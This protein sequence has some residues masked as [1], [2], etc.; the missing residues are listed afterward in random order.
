MSE[1][2]DGEATQVT[3]NQ[4]ALVQ[5]VLARYP[6][7]FTVFRE[8]VQNADDAGAENVEIEFQTKD[9]ATKP[10][11][12]KMTNGIEHDLTNVKAFKWVV[13]NDG[14]AFEDGGW[15]RLTN[16][17]DGNPDDQKIGAF[18]VGFFSV[19]SITECPV[20][21]SGNRCK[22]M[23]YKGD[24]LMF[25]F[26]SYPETKW[27]TIEMEVK[28]E[29][30]PMPKPFDLSTFFCTAVT[31]LTKVKRV[32]ILFNGQLL[33]EITKFRGE[34]QKIEE[35]PKE[36]KKKSKS[37][38]MT[39]K[40]V[41]MIPAQQV[42]VTLSKLGRSAGSKKSGVGKTAPE[43]EDA[44]PTKRAG[45]FGRK[46]VEPNRAGTI[47]RTSSTHANSS[48]VN[49]TIYSAH[50]S[51]TP[52]EEMISGLLEA[53]KKRP[54]S[55]FLYEAVHFTRE[56]YQRAMAD[57][58]EEDSIGSV[59][60]GVQALCSEKEEGHASRLFIGQSTAQ[61][62]GIAVHLSSRFTP[63]VER[64]SIDLALKDHLREEALYIMKCFTSRQ[65]TPDSKVGELLQNAFFN[66]STSPSFPILSN[67]GIRDS[68][69]VRQPHTDFKPFMK[70]RPVLDNAL[71][72]INSTMIEQ[73]PERYAVTVYTFRDVKLELDSRTFSEEEMIAC[74]GWWVRSFGIQSRQM[75]GAE[76]NTVW[77][78]EFSPV[79]K[80]RSSSKSSPRTMMLSGINKFVD[81]RPR[82]SFV[83]NDDPL[84][85]DT[86]PI[87]FTRSLDAN[88]VMA[89]LGWEPLT[90][91]DWIRY[92]T[93]S[94]LDSPQDICKTAAFSERVLATLPNLWQSIQPT[95][96]DKIIA[97]LQSVACIPTN[98]GHRMPQNAYFPEADL[99]NELPV[100][101]FQQPYI[102]YEVVL[103]ALGVKRSLDW[104][105]VK[106]RLVSDAECSMMRLVA[107]LQS[108]RQWMDPE[109]FMA[110]KQLA[111]FACEAAAEGQVRRCIHEVYRPDQ[112]HRALELPVLV[113][114]S[115]RTFSQF[116][117]PEVGFDYL[118]EFGL[119]QHPPLNLIIEKASSTNATVRQHA[120][121]FFVNHLEDYYEKYNPADFPN[122]SFLPC[123]KGNRPTQ[124]GTPEEV[125]TSS[126]WEIFGFHTIHKSVL[127]RTQMKL[128]LKD[129]PS[130]AVI[131]KAMQTKSP[132]SIAT[133]KKW[134][135]LLARKGGF[136]SDDLAL[137][138]E[139]EIV[140]VERDQS[141]ATANGTIPESADPPAVAPNKCFYA[142]P[143]STKEHH[144]AIFTYMDY[145]QP[146]NS[147]LKM[148]GAKPNPDCSD[149]VEAMI[150]N[151][152][153]Y[154]NKIE[155]YLEL[156]KG[157]KTQ[158]YKSYLDDLRQVAA[159]F[160]S[161]SKELK[162]R[163]KR[164]PIFI[165]F[166]KK[167]RVSDDQLS[168][169][170]QQYALKHA[171]EILI[172]D[173]LESHRLFGEHVFVGPK[174]EVFENFY[175]DHGSASL[176]SHVKHVVNYG[177]FVTD[178]EDLRYHVF[179][180]LKIFLHDQDGTR[181]TNFNVSQ[182]RE[183]GAF[184][185]KYCKTLKISKSLEF[186]HAKKTD[187]STSWIPIEE[188]ALAGIQQ[189]QGKDTLWMIQQ[190]D[191]G[192]KDWYDVAVAL[193]RIIFTMHK[194]HDTLLLMTI[195]DADLDDLRRRGYDV[196]NIRRNYDREVERVDQTAP[197][198]SSRKKKEDGPPTRSS[199]HMPSWLKDLAGFKKKKNQPGDFV[200]D[201]KMD[202]R[203][204]SAVKM[205]KSDADMRSSNK[206]Q[207]KSKGGNKQ[208]DV[209]YCSSRQT[210]LERCRKDTTKNGML[211]F[212][213]P[214][215][216][217]P[218]ESSLE[219]FS[220]ILEELGKLFD[221]SV[222]KLH[223]F[224]Q[225]GDTELMGFNRNKA[226]YLNLAHFEDKHLPLPPDD[227]SRATT[228]AAWYF[229]IAHEIAHNI[230]FFHDE[231][232]ELLFSSIAQYRASHGSRMT[233][234]EVNHWDL[235][236]LDTPTFRIPSQS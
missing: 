69:D 26:G 210:D 113:W 97:L 61:T 172:A 140:P 13:K 136:S 211:V 131:I 12:D 193:C 76:V 66:C 21:I 169:E 234:S 189:T 187:D 43:K 168:A 194:T 205:C 165:S 231:D 214:D 174:E 39:V 33:S 230:A 139:M 75:S 14:A 108:V 133:A 58:N 17:A 233:D 7:E 86:I 99:F 160:H 41:E 48:V 176:S 217:D 42:R 1:V 164:A 62:S 119:R 106:D 171:H 85:P 28:D 101:Q 38:T 107:Y 137:I 25:D 153:E 143:D 126:E 53:T 144:L 219:K 15:R 23:F 197:D 215:Q 18:G 122:S 40:S 128:K 27:T 112:F 138:S 115:G 120:Y 185:V 150:S 175:R 82:F 158:A 96:K 213:T 56:E 94:G 5:K 130:A 50:I 209:K 212:K 200:Q 157:D 91:V 161:L 134:F 199:F 179:D 226:I 63:T 208:R 68:K 92:L 52:T 141:V 223:I 229:I 29:Q 196:D 49:Y 16:I 181:R 83:Q 166:R 102:D 167:R 186:E 182:W 19:F 152:Q 154:L 127:P 93:G 111:I 54:P 32:T 105:W 46:N 114:G 177:G 8:L 135:D 37:G 74:I 60:R 34:A 77:K 159:G 190:P 2:L 67:L 224:W 55:S 80:F 218:P 73:L 9:Y 146:A 87:P 89:A 36:L 148:C 124:F 88:Q 24:Q 192:R 163:M 65:S 47:S 228:Y 116:G 145:R 203:V 180:R 30:L 162:T 59:F 191:S 70:E 11:G 198:K 3:V 125:F 123:G 57:G 207:D 22:R 149:I 118:Y 78:D 79:A 35:L 222:E 45:F 232:H 44:N 71:W 51:S 84:P 195:L 216:E 121:N 156:K 109:E 4:R 98:Q 132:P 6:E 202:D 235:G 129:R 220:G 184:T 90:I 206:D 178:A 64:G 117:V 147:F 142:V 81:T 110:V 201:K 104:N 236:F 204:A 221:L 155:M 227:D 10:P 151:P 72:L 31:F 225:P 95:D 173:D 103:Q 20:V 100:V 170:S 183:R 188:Q